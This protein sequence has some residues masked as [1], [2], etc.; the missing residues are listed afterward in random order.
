MVMARV[1]EDKANHFIIGSIAAAAGLHVAMAYGLDSK[2]GA[3]AFAT[4]VGVAI[5]VIQKV[6]KSGVFD[7]M[8]IVATAAGAIPVVLA[9]I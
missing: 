9:E 6:T 8:D 2:V 4:F 3:V 1:P 7:P 5:E